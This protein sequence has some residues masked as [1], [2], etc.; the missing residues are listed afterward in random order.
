MGGKRRKRERKEVKEKIRHTRISRIC[1]L[2]QLFEFDLI[3]YVEASL[4]RLI[5]NLVVE[6]VGTC[7]I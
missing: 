5:L 6:E 4:G 7:K 2:D 1:D 3:S